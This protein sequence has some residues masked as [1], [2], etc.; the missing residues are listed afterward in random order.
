MEDFKENLADLLEVDSVNDSD[1]F[2]SFDT[3]DSL[4]IL[5]I[6]AYVDED[7]GVSVS[8]QKLD[9]VETVGG[10]FKYIQN[11]Q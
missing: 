6:I 4:T 11:N 2:N 9:E 5:S 1:Y 10:L 7:F 8:A 3:W